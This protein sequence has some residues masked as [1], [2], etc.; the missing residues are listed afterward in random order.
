[1]TYGV[2]RDSEN[3]TIEV[4]PEMIEA[5]MLELRERCY[6]ESL[7]EVVARVFSAMAAASQQI[8]ATLR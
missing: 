4:T 8:D 5:G 7:S 1:M 6:G 3:A 2:T